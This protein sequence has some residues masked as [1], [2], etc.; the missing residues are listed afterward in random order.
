MSDAPPQELIDHIK[1]LLARPNISMLSDRES[2]V[3]SV[4]LYDRLKP[5]EKMELIWALRDA[6][7][8]IEAQQ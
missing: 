5:T 7:A 8:Y 6:L 1:D 3:K 2:Y 4:A